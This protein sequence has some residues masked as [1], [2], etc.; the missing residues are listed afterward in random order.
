MALPEAKIVV[1]FAGG[2]ETKQDQ[3]TVL[4]AKLLVLE[5][6]V[7]TR[8]ISLVK[9]F[10]Y[11]SLGQIVLG[12][13]TTLPTQVALGRRQYELVSFSRDEAHSYVDDAGAWVRSGDLQSCICDHEAIAKTGGDQTLGDMAVHSGIAVYA[14]EDSRGGVWSAVYDDYTGRAIVPPAQLD[15]G[16][17]RPRVHAV[18]A[19]LHVY[20][21]RTAAQEIHARRIDPLLP[22]VAIDQVLITTVSGPLPLYDVDQDDEK[23]VIAWRNT[24]SEIS[25]GYIHESAVLGGPGLGLAAPVAITNN[26]TNVLS[27]ALDKLDDDR[28]IAV[29]WSGSSKSYV[30][31]DEDLVQEFAPRTF[32]DPDSGGA[33]GHMTCVFLRDSNDAGDRQLWIVADDGGTLDIVRNILTDSNPSVFTTHDIRVQ[34]GVILGSKAFTDDEDAYVHTMHDSTIFRTYFGQ[35]IDDGL[36]VSRFLPAI[37]G[38]PVPK[39]H[40]PSVSDELSPFG[41]AVRFAA[42]YAEQAGPPGTFAERGL[43]RVS[44]DFLSPDAYRSAQL[45]R[46]LYIGGGLLMAYDGQAV[47]EAGFHVGPDDLPDPVVGVASVGPG[48]GAGTVGYIAVYE[49]IMPNGELERSPTSPT[50]TAVVAAPGSNVTLDIP[51]YRWPKDG[52]RIGLYRS[53][54]NGSA[55]FRRVASVDPTTAGQVNGYIA[56]DSTANSVTFVDEMDEATRLLQEPLYTTGGIPS[57]A[58][59][60]SAR[61]VAAGKGRLFTVDPSEPNR[62]FVTHELDPGVAAEFGAGIVVDVDAFGGDINGLIVMDDKIVPF[63]ETAIFAFAGAGPAPNPDSPTG[64]FSTPQLVTSD[65]GCVAPDS[66]VYTPVGVMFQ[67]QKGIYQLGRDLSV[68]YVG[69]DVEAYNAQTIV[70]ATLIEDRTQI[71]FLTDSGRTLLYDYLFQQWSTFTNH[72]G[73]DAVLVDGIYHYVR[74]D[75]VIWRETLGEYRDDNSQIKLRVGTA[76]LH[77]VEHT[78]GFHRLWDFTLLGEWRST[79]TLRVRAFYDYEDGFDDEWTFVPATFINLP[80]YGEGLYGVGDYGEGSGGEPSRRYQVN[81]HIGRQCTAVRFEFEFLE[82]TDDAGA[83]GELTELVLRGGVLGQRYPLTDQRRA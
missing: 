78:Q 69:A 63:K 14:W 24:D 59:L 2:V 77:L 52:V 30:M 17:E 41:R 74:K 3:K 46:T 38:G 37:A 32:S 65:V 15:A 66:L 29:A 12:A 10:G 73:L 22:T 55:I 18:G 19:F 5:N 68:S 53:E 61:L 44:L 72:E 21:V 54:P 6:A 34:R 16:G 83:A 64:G 9:R 40:L 20:W 56:N 26:P 4:P 82:A 8:A 51:T 47:N 62:I 81:G 71:R 75:G 45:G 50:V 70:A 7:F 33:S 25:V 67:S 35:R 28:R 36:A 79:H 49:R 1:R 23:A 11:E 39:A 58:S 60:G 42:I 13:D 31:L 76:W 80:G 57:N 48:L 27:I 43:R